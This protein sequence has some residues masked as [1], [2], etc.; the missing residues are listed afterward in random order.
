M[1][2]RRQKSLSE[3][4]REG[5]G[6]NQ[7]WA[8]PGQGHSPRPP[9]L[10]PSPLCSPG[11]SGSR[12]PPH[13]MGFGVSWAHKACLRLLRKVG[14]QRAQSGRRGGAVRRPL[15]VWMGPSSMWESVASERKSFL[16]S[17]PGPQSQ[18]YSITVTIAHQHL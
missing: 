5:E 14:L 3:E 2:L 4:G 15:P 17:V 8:K 10:P 6:D 16:L 18:L 12:S 13:F 11:V 7:L 9:P 1:R